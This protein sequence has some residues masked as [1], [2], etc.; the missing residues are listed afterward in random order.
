MKIRVVS[1]CYNEARMLPFF[2]RHYETFAD[3]I[4]IYDDRSD[5]GSCELLQAHPKVVGH[6]CPFHGLNDDEMLNL[7][8]AELK[9]SPGKCDWV[10]FPDIDEFLIAPDGMRETLEKLGDKYGAIQSTAFNMTGNGVPVD[11]GRQI[12]EINNSG[13]Y[14]PVYSKAIILKA[15]SRIEWHRGRHQYDSCSV[16]VSPAAVRLLH[17]RYL[18]SD[19]TK[20]R[21]ARNYERV[22]RDKGCAWSNAPDYQGQHSATWAGGIMG[23]GQNV[24]EQPLCEQPK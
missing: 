24:F 4:V 1:C 13:V 15:G 9:A 20:S 11:D 22:G 14:S 10:M 5:D 21:N 12:Y 8:Y 16:P 19:Y 18:G 2:L 3:E 6:N 17:Y 23:S 7:W